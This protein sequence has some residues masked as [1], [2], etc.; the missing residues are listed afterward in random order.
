MVENEAVS[1]VTE[2]LSRSSHDGAAIFVPSDDWS[3][4]IITGQRISSLGKVPIEILP[5]KCHITWVLAVLLFTLEFQMEILAPYA[6]SYDT[7]TVT[8]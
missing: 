2:A 6:F 7:R 4:S 1:S 5:G 3:I 8:Y